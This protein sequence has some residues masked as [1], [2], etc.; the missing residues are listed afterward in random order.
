MAGLYIHHKLGWSGVSGTDCSLVSV[1]HPRYL[2]K[3]LQTTQETHT[4]PG[5]GDLSLRQEFAVQIPHLE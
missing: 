3:V 5:V 1:V 2:A 4:L